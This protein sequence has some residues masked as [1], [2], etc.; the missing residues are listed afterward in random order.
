M[1]SSSPVDPYYSILDFD[2]ESIVKPPLV[3]RDMESVVLEKP[4][5]YDME[6]M[7]IYKEVVNDMLKDE[8]I[9]SITIARKFLNTISKKYHTQITGPMIIWTY[10]TMYQNGEIEKYEHKYENYFRTKTYRSKDGVLVVTV[11]MPAYPEVLLRKGEDAESILGDSINTDKDE[12]EERI[13]RRQE[14]RSKKR[15]ELK[16]EG[17]K[18]DDSDEEFNKEETTRKMREFSCRHDCH[19]C[20]SQKGQPRSYFLKEPGVLRAHTLTVPYDILQQIWT[21]LDQYLINGHPV[22]KIELLV[23]GGTFNSYPKIIRYRFIQGLVYAVNTF[24][25]KNRLIKPRECKSIEMEWEINR[26]NPCKIIGLT[27]ETRPDYITE[28]FLKE[29]RK[30]Q[31]TRIQMGVQHTNN[32]ILERVNRGHNFETVITASKRLLDGGFKFDIHLMPDLPLPV[33]DEVKEEINNKLNELKKIKST[34]T[35]EEYRQAIIDIEDNITWDDIDKSK[36]MRD[37]DREM[38]DRILYSGEVGFDQVK[39]YP[40]QVVDFTRTKKWAENGLHKSYYDNIIFETKEEHEKYNEMSSEEKKAYEL[41]HNELFYLMVDVLEETHPWVRINR[42]IRDIPSDYIRGGTDCVN[43]RQ[44]IENYAVKD[45][46]KISE[47]RYCEKEARPKLDGCEEDEDYS[48]FIDR[49]IYNNGE[50]YTIYC[51]NDDRTKIFGFLRLR[52]SEETSGFK[53]LEGCGKIRELHVY[54]QLVE[55]DVKR[56]EALQHKGL[57]KLMLDVAEFIT[58]IHGLKKISVIAGNGTYMYYSKFGYVEHEY[59]MIKDIDEKIKEKIS[60]IQ[61]NHH[62]FPEYRVRKIETYLINKDNEKKLIKS[63]IIDYKE[64]KEIIDYREKE[65]YMRSQ[66]NILI[67]PYVF[68]L[69]AILIIITINLDDTPMNLM[70]NNENLM[71]NNENL[72][73]NNENLMTNNENLMINNENLMT[74]NENLMIN[75][76]DLIYK[77]CITILISLILYFFT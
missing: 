4:L 69:L 3:M 43:Y 51:G 77:I 58:L 28:D 40:H 1:C 6:K 11:F 61:V 67:K 64:R 20:P 8:S 66:M 13:K 54:G 49:V 65:D 7:D 5:R 19:F 52:I 55:T 18:M 2:E 50:N 30:L 73:I 76:E 27:I 42:L 46:R 48:V 41:T 37:I 56:E 62:S 10:R 38:F 29:L 59:F 22:D 35:K 17:S 63:E 39:Y 72:M 34:M 68:L 60:E 53:E 26:T 15:I 44:I 45:K 12:Y 70:I 33:K 32:R 31:I 16:Y 36:K 21:R 25:D 71:I 24:F 47:L 23:L 14:R 9:N 74:N 75:N 57:G